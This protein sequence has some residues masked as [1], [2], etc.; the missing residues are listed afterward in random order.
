MDGHRFEDLG[1]LGSSI[2]G[3]AAT[4]DCE[5]RFNMSGKRVLVLGILG[6]A[7]I[8]AGFW[9]PST[10]FYV[11]FQRTIL[12]F[13]PR[14]LLGSILWAKPAEAASPPESGEGRTGGWGQILHGGVVFPLPPGE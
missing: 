2:A 12:A 1:N 5:G 8:L 14:G 11:I 3:E 4:Q 13:D 7:V 9:L 6:G 10:V